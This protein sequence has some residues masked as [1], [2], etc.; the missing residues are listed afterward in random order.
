MV[1]QA[2]QWRPAASSIPDQLPVCSRSLSCTNCT[3]E[4]KACDCRCINV[5]GVCVPNNFGIPR[6]LGVEHAGSKDCSPATMSLPV[7]QE[8][9]RRAPLENDMF[10]PLGFNAPV[11]YTFV[12]KV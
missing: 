9:G 1:K 5:A 2:V 10:S 7:M 11:V 4:L 8:L 3:S 12:K 6:E